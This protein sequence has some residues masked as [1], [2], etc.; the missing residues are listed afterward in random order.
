MQGK[1]HFSKDSASPLGSSLWI[2]S[3]CGIPV[4]DF[5]LRD[6][7]SFLAFQISCFR[8]VKTK[9]NKSFKDCCF[10]LWFVTLFGII[11]SIFPL[12]F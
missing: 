3:Y 9:Q 2:L 10:L 12:D 8:A 4:L 1:I 11:G 6:I 7:P 5:S